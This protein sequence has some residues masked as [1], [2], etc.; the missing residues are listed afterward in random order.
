M[1]EG[2]SRQMTNRYARQMVLPEVGAE[3]QARVQGAHVLVVGAG[4]LGC[5]VL[6]YLCAAGVGRLTIVDHDRVEE[7]NLHRQPLYRM[8]D[9]GLP[10]AR[11]AR[12]ALLDGN[13]EVIIEA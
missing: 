11:S 3:G 1:A 8:S 6:Q 7:A 10:K 9:L 4:G 12:T 5:A 2:D 13:P